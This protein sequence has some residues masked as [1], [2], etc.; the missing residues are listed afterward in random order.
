MADQG[1]KIDLNR[2]VS[3]RI[4]PDSK[5]TVCMYKD[6]PGIYYD[7][8]GRLLPEKIAAKAGFNI[9]NESTRRKKILKLKEA[10]EEIEKEF[11][12][13]DENE[14]FYQRGPYK[15]I[16]RGNNGAEIIDEDGNKISSGVMP[17]TEAK[18]LIDAMFDNK[19]EIKNEEGS[20]SQE[21]GR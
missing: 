7:I 12:S 14:V 15:A 9:K 5:I 20:K 4:V 11:S 19:E 21:E 8:A 2:G 13:V 18:T 17:K 6:D 16:A 3:K 1:I 10:R